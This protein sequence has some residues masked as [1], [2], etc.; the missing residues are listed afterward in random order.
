[1]KVKC[2]RYDDLSLIRLRSSQN[3]CVAGT[4][5]GANW[6]NCGTGNGEGGD[7]CNAGV[8]AVNCNAFGAEADSGIVGGCKNGYSAGN[9]ADGCG[10]T[11]ETLGFGYTYC[12]AGTGA[13]KQE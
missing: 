10:P 12:K 8:A 7:P 9:A 2:L 13:N 3:A 5:A 4:I 11:G 6:G 1:M